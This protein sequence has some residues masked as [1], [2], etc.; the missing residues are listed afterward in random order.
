MGVGVVVAVMLAFFVV[1]PCDNVDNAMDGDAEFVLELRGAAVVRVIKV[2]FARMD[3]K[4]LSGETGLSVEAVETFE[5]VP[6]VLRRAMFCRSGFGGMLGFWKS[7]LV[8]T[9]PSTHNRH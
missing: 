6:Q 5:L 8:T 4:V 9:L 2:L 7:T 3:D 1:G